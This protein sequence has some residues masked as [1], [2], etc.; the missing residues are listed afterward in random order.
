MGLK[1]FFVLVELFIVGVFLQLFSAL[2]LVKSH[3]ILKSWDFWVPSD[4]P[5]VLL[6]VAQQPVWFCRDA[7]HSFSKS[8]HSS[9]NNNCF[10]KSLCQRYL[11]PELHKFNTGLVYGF[12][13]VCVCVLWVW[14]V[15]WYGM[16][17][18]LDMLVFFCTQFCH[19]WTGTVFYFQ[20]CPLSSSSCILSI[21]SSWIFFSCCLFVNFDSAGGALFFISSATVALVL[22]FLCS[23]ANELESQRTELEG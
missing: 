23:L 20:W 9:Q 16:I 3:F 19:M 7:S 15:G 11:P 18:G 1:S 8:S 12:S 6:P 2:R 10:Q 13:H 17:P 5:H 22:P 4:F 14:D 21:V